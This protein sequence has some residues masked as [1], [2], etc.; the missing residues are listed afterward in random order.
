MS[1]NSPDNNF[2]APT[3]TIPPTPV[4]APPTDPR[5]RRAQSQ[6]TRYTTNK[7]ARRDDNDEE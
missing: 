4:T 7:C 1:A 2:N 3:L 5:S 6:Q